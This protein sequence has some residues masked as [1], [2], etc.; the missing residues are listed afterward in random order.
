VSTIKRYYQAGRLPK[1]AASVII[2]MPG[3]VAAQKLLVKMWVAGNKFRAHPYIPN[4]ADTLC[5]M[6]DNGAI[7]SS[8]ACGPPRPAPS[9]LAPTGPRSTDARWQP[10]GR[11]ERCAPTRR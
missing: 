8:G 2:K 6:L 9:A 3:K 4:K 1:N 11:S 5:G 10:V 7:Q